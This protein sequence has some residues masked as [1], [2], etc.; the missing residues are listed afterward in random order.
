LGT[1]YKEP[2]VC[3]T[4]QKWGT[5]FCFGTCRQNSIRRSQTL[6]AIWKYS[7][8]M[9][10]SLKRYNYTDALHFITFSCY[11]RKPSLSAPE[12]RDLF[13]DIIEKMR[14]KYRFAVCG[15]VVMPEHVHLLVSEPEI[16]NCSVVI[17]A[18]KI[19][20]VR[21][22]FGATHNSQ[23]QGEGGTR[24]LFFIQTRSG[25]SASTTS[26]STVIASSSRSCDTYTAIRSNADW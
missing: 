17:R 23:P 19:A 24:V 26:T 20:F 12:R 8:V 18:I 11:Q 9:P 4:R 14:L 1:S 3:Q 10:W 22:K 6:S 21:R 16:A 13:L 5:R 25:R 15:Y 2:H 7:G